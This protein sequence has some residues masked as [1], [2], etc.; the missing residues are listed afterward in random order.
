MLQIHA[1]ISSNASYAASGC[2]RLSRG[3]TRRSFETTGNNHGLRV[4]EQHLLGRAAEG[5][6]RFAQALA[7]RRGVLADSKAH[8]ARR[9]YLSVA[10][11]VTSGARPRRMAVKSACIC[12]PRGVSKR[13]TGSAAT[14]LAGP[15]C[16]ELADAVFVTDLAQFPKQYRC[17][18]PV[19]PRGGDTF[20]QIALERVEL[21]RA[22]LARL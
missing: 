19:W 5:D 1:A 9:L 10:T 22:W 4:V 3:R 8:E 13:T 14:R 12:L 16:P 21:R 6:E 11:G 20:E 17:R 18:N 7:Q 15:G 2:C